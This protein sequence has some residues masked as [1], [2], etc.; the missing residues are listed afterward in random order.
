MNILLA[1][2]DFCSY[3]FSDIGFTSAVPRLVQCGFGAV[4]LG[5]AGLFLGCFAS[6]CIVICAI[7][8][9]K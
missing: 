9:P 3:F 5:L 6:V 1:K 7:D 2:F 8:C 4:F